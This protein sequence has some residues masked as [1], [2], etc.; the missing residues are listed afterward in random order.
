M[1]QAIPLLSES[2]LILLIALFMF[3]VTLA[4]GVM[5]YLVQGRVDFSDKQLLRKE[6]TLKLA[7][8]D[9]NYFQ[10]GYWQF[11][12]QNEDLKREVK[13]WKDRY[14][15]LYADFA[16]VYRDTLLDR[17]FTILVRAKFRN[18]SDIGALLLCPMLWFLEYLDSTFR[19]DDP[20][21]QGGETR[22]VTV[23][24]SCVVFGISQ[25]NGTV[26]LFMIDTI[27]PLDKVTTEVIDETKKKAISSNVL[28]FCITNGDEFVLVNLV[29]GGVFN[30]QSY[31]FSV[32]DIK[33]H[34]P[35]VQKE[36]H[37]GAFKLL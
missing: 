29:N 22:G 10:N 4:I 5:A 2:Y 14:D 21:P 32:K 15:V 9:L 12:Q 6:T 27:P 23:Y 3:V 26:P 25:N 16:R 35:H 1:L 33:K 7:E 34:W 17:W 18:R 20:F 31:H 11:Y 19:F 37:S 24:V 8:K 28:K 36:L 13:V 30:V